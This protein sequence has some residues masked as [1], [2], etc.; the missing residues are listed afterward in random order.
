MN[1]CGLWPI[2]AQWC[3]VP[4]SVRCLVAITTGHYWALGT[5][6]RHQTPDGTGHQQAP[7]T[8]E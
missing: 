5:G 2:G 4:S 7:G 8:R 3:P 1:I 6:T